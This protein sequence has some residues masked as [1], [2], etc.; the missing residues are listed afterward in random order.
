[1][2]SRTRGKP[3]RKTISIVYVVLDRDRDS[4]TKDV[5]GDG[6]QIRSCLIFLLWNR[7]D[8][9]LLQ[10]MENGKGKEEKRCHRFGL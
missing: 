8:R 3:Q 1:M 9:I 10:V 6:D 7:N 4:A 2:H 5:K